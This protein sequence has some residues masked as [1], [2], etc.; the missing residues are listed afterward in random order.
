MSQTCFECRTEFTAP[1]S[2]LHSV[3][4]PIC[5]EMLGRT[6]RPVSIGE[7]LGGKNIPAELRICKS[8]GETYETTYRFAVHCSPCKAR[9]RKE[10]AGWEEVPL[11]PETDINKRLDAVDFE[12]GRTGS[13][14]YE[15]QTIAAASLDYYLKGQESPPDDPHDLYYIA[16]AYLD[17]W[18]D[19]HA[20]CLTGGVGVGKTGCAAAI[21]REV[22][23]KGET[24]QFLKLNHF[25]NR[26]KTAPDMAEFDRREIECL[27]G[28][29][30]LVIDEI[31][32]EVMTD[33]QRQRFED[34]VDR[35]YV[36]RAPT[37]F[38]SN[39]T[40]QAFTDHVGD[41]MASRLHDWCDGG[42]MMYELA[43]ADRRLRVG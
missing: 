28:M 6:A 29:P 21:A 3:I 4:C 34:V 37:I 12:L 8:C 17:N 15:R 39:L 36:N 10:D 7:V 38:C 42:R 1:V 40:Q 14:L 26:W 33:N 41:A 24:V 16:V 20:L 32:R 19:K 23:M 43:G 13:R 27:S 31:G 11:P 30:L 2:N 35:R 25:V 18:P 9:I 5:N 22:V